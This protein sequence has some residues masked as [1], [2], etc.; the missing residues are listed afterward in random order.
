MYLVTARHI[1]QN[2]VSDQIYLR[3]N[4][5]SGKPVYSG[6]TPP[7]L[8]FCHDSADV[9]L[10]R[11]SVEQETFEDLNIRSIEAQRLV[12]GDFRYHGPFEGEQATSPD[13]RAGM[14]VNIGD[15]VMMVTLL[16]ES[17]GSTKNLPIARFG[18][19]SRMPEE[20]IQMRGEESGIAFKTVP[21]LCEAHS[22]GG[23]SG[24]PTYIFFPTYKI[25]KRRKKQDPVFL[26][27]SEFALMGLVSGHFDRETA[28]KTPLADQAKDR[29]SVGQNT[30]MMIITPSHHI[31]ELLEREDVVADRLTAI[32]G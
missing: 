9:A 14:P 31:T 22:L 5:K 3:I 2:G 1:I 6:Q 24:S 11:F 17:A 27:S 7:T 18:R 25:L 19:V 16:T 26:Q 15:E 13:R 28:I 20:P 12:G 10:L 8:W 23:V 21:Y 29:L 32:G 30:N 4:S